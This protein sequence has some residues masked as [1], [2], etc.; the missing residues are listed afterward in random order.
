MTVSSSETRGLQM[1]RITNR[2]AELLKAEAHPKRR[3]ETRFLKSLAVLLLVVMEISVLAGSSIAAPALASVSH[4]GSGA[5]HSHQKDLPRHSPTD[6]R[7]CIAGHSS[8]IVLDRFE[9]ATHLDHLSSI[10]AG[11]NPQLLVELTLTAE[12][13]VRGSSIPPL[14]MS[15]RI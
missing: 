7:C 13:N 14:L 6:L 5:C 9:T 1:A 4:P 8:A 2:Q 10:K 15:L 11:G 12:D 3:V